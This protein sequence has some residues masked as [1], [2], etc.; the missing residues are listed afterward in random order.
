MNK[1]GE[2]LDRVGTISLTEKMILSKDLKKM[3]KLAM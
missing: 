1:G 3:G 2:V